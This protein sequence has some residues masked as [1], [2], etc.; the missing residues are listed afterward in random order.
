MTI[1]QD[2]LDR[3]RALQN[4]R[5]PWESFW[6]DIARYALPDAERFDGMFA[7]R[8]R[9]AAIDSVVSEPIAAR[10][11]REIYD[12]T[13]LWA[14]DRG[15]AG[16]MSLITPQ[17]ETW[18][19]L[20]PEDPF[21]DE[22]DENGKEWLE[23]VRDFLFK[24]RA[25][26]ASG[27]WTAHK[28]ATR[29]KWAFG[30][31]VTF[32][33]EHEKGDVTAP[34]L[35]RYVPLSE[36]HLGCDFNGVIDTNF[37]LLRRSARSCMQRWGNKVSAKTMAYA[38]SEKD[39]DRMVLLLHAVMPRKE[40]GS[41][42]SGLKG[43]SDFASYYV[44][45]D[46]K[47]L[48]GDSGYWEFP[49]HVYHWQRNNP[50]P[51]AEGPMAIALA[52]VKSLNMLAKS[53][54]QAAQQWVKPPMAVPSDGINRL[55]LNPGAMNVGATDAQGNLLA[56]PL[57]TGQRPD[58]AQTVLETRRN[59]VRESLYV[60]LWQILIQ[61][62]Q[63]TATEAMIRANEKGDLLG[64]VGNAAQV[65]LSH[66]VDREISILARM[67]AFD[68]G[69]ALQP[70]EEMEGR[71]IGV[72]FTSP[73]DRLR[74]GNEAVAIERLWA[75]AGQI[76]QA[77]AAGGQPPEIL[78]LLDADD[79]IR[80]LRDIFGAPASVI[81]TAAEVQALRKQRAQAAQAMQLAQGAQMGGEAAKSV[82]DGMQA[83]TA[84]ANGGR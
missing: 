57:F 40:K 33:E 47:H 13:S 48:I 11:S 56:K 63:M 21:M 71:S 23:Y 41:K 55:N 6:W 5:M 70:P 22:P 38:E 24:T 68:R 32:S 72:R 16:E 62:P 15:V 26:P 39:K 78:D 79:S 43:G 58:F 27:F 84:A 52:D 49:F 69:S 45:V 7:G 34:I 59:Q 81:K 2:L 50:G 53:E 19:D 44:E 67:G 46:N 74:R 75:S 3:L 17:S 64:P 73:L 20:A 9:G 77:Q 82:G 42:A 8:D 51:Y 61:N 54:L 10:R 28:A 37:R 80:Q 83:L 60:N 30:T 36:C 25:N 66:M 1:V 18:H 4:D 65:T 35:Y 31:G 76:A 14:I 29:S 12:Q